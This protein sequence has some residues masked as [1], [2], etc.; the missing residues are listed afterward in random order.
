MRDPARIPKL[1]SLLGA[2][3]QKSGN[4]DLRLGQILGN[5]HSSKD[6]YFLEDDVLI[7]ILQRELE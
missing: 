1:L 2:Y 4:Q 7:E 3:W 6:V 5:F